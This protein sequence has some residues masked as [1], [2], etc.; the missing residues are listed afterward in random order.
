MTTTWTS[1]L[2]QT[3]SVWRPH[4]LLL[5]RN[6]LKHLAK[7]NTNELTPV[8]RKTY[9]FK[10]QKQKLYLDIHPITDLLYLGQPLPNDILT[11][12]TNYN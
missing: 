6:Q 4:P 1:N 8:Y 11:L 10:M 2:T 5:F 7:A 9:K 12:S 3:F